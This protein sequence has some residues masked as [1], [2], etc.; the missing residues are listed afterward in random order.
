M[1][2]FWTRENQLRGQNAE[3]AT[4]LN[5][6]E[7]AYLR[8]RN[9]GS[10]KLSAYI[11]GR[12]G[13]KRFSI[14]DEHF[15]GRLYQGYIDYRLP[16]KS[17]LLGR[18][19]DLRLGRQFLPNDTGFW[20]MDGVRLGIRNLGPIDSKLYG[21]VAATPWMIEKKRDGIAGIELSRLKVWRI[22]SRISFLTVFDKD[23][24][25]NV[26]LGMRLD[27]PRF[28][29]F[30]IHRD[31]HKRLNFFGRGSIDLLTRQFV[32]GYGY[33]NFSPVSPMHLSL[34]YQRETP[35]FPSDSIFSIFAF[36]PLR[37]A[38]AVC[39][40]DIL[41]GLELYGRY[42]RQFFD[43]GVPINRY[44]TG[45]SINSHYERILDIRLE[46]L[47]DI[48]TKQWRIH[49][50][51]GKMLTPRLEVAFNHYYNNY[52]LTRFQAADAY[53]YQLNLKYQVLRNLSAF[54][55]IEDNKNVYYDYNV[56]VMGYI[57]MFFEMGQ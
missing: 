4:N 46:R 51:I 54:I 52:E 8:A 17:S 12:I 15:T 31:V 45:F 49:S 5:F 18:V 44:S 21:G 29:L 16:K 33:I 22:R 14:E 30:D 20:Q 25:N 47:S 2:A 55:R 19:G 10:D 11:R 53:S 23:G 57:R 13:W 32:S 9:I 27:F 56:R 35:L 48:H 34:E 24:F 37:Q 50:Y 39:Q 42:A 1:S 26:I 41:N 38:A 28:N 7:Y 40:I 36:E 43:D 3:G 6:Y